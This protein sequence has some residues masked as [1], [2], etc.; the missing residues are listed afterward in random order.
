MCY[1]FLRSW[2]LCVRI[3]FTPVDRPLTLFQSEVGGPR[4]GL[5]VVDMRKYLLPLLRSSSSYMDWAI[6]TGLDISVLGEGT[7]RTSNSISGLH[8][9]WSCFGC[10]RR[11]LR[12]RSDIRRASS[13]WLTHFLPPHHVIIHLNQFGHCADGGRMFLRYGVTFDHCI[14]QKPVR[15]VI[16]CHCSAAQQSAAMNPHKAA[17]TRLTNGISSSIM[18][19]IVLPTPDIFIICVAVRALPSPRPLAAASSQRFEILEIF[20]LS[21][22]RLCTAICVAEWGR[23]NSGALPVFYI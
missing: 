21:A 23:T 19:C 12:V 17:P 9:C 2:L 18:F 11:V 6:T 22:C 4:D 10:L 5:D 13:G 14:V 16:I 20:W 7:L 3:K 8:G 1:W 15:H